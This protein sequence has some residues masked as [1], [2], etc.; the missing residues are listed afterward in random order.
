[1]CREDSSARSEDAACAV[2]TS[3]R[4]PR[5]PRVPVKKLAM[6]RSEFTTRPSEL[7]T[8]PS[9]FT[10]RPSEFTMRPNEFA[11]PRRRRRS[12]ATD[13]DS[14]VFSCGT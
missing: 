14:E 9:E 2:K 13:L 7:R 12:F 3:P 4:T 1:V 8:R 11:T 5:R 6:R 10:M